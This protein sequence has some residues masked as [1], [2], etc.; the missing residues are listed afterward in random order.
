MAEPMSPDRPL[1]LMGFAEALAAIETAWSL[2]AADFKVVA[3][4]PAGNRPALRH[5]R[6][7]EV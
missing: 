7:L 4:C 6:G 1:V 3:F 5:V 2:Q